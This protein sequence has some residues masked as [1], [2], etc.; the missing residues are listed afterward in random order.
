M[1]RKASPPWRRPS[2]TKRE[3]PEVNSCLKFAYDDYFSGS[4][5]GTGTGAFTT[6]DENSPVCGGFGFPR[7]LMTSLQSSP[8]AR[9]SATKRQPQRTCAPR[10]FAEEEQ[11]LA[12]EL[13]SGIHRL[14]WRMSFRLTESRSRSDAAFNSGGGEDVCRNRQTGN[15]PIYGETKVMCGKAP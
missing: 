2:S 14:A 8:L 6:F 11:A 7:T 9:A 4:G 15:L 12:L 1:R 3:R 10:Y 13:L 5:F